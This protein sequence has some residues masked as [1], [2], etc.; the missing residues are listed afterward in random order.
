MRKCILCKE[1]KDDSLFNKEH[2]ILESLGGT[3]TIKCVCKNCNSNF[4][5]SVD[6]LASD[7]LTAIRYLLNIAGKNGI[8]NPYKETKT[9][10]FYPLEF[11]DDP[12]NITNVRVN[13]EMDAN[14]KFKKCT[15]IPR[16]YEYK[17]GKLIV[18]DK[19]NVSGFV[20]KALNENNGLSA[21]VVCIKKKTYPDKLD[22]G[23]FYFIP[24]KYK[25]YSPK[26]LFYPH[27]EKELDYFSL[28]CYPI[29]LKMAYE[30]F[31]VVSDMKYLN[32]A[33]AEPIRLFLKNFDK[34]GV[35]NLPTNATGEHLYKKMDDQEWE[36]WMNLP[37]HN[38]TVNIK[39]DNNN[40]IA[41]VDMFHFFNYKIVMSENA[42]E[43]REF[44]D[45]LC[46]KITSKIDSFKKI[47]PKFEIDIVTIYIRPKA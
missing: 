8:P 24:K 45:T 27:T 33:L 43:Y 36:K 19:K 15:A 1:I 31:C 7:T 4:G 47:D 44:D 14:G 40:I 22:E 12:G 9:E 34:K 37:D 6:V 28:C 23:K 42:S 26:V 38:I 39:T 5:K 41:T 35:N 32:D 17:D 2:I 21:P 25:Q 3:K 18:S 20:K 30:Y 10:T 46:N 11:E 29:A 13:M 16:V